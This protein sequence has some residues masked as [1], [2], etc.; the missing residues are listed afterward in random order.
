MKK[1]LDSILFY[2]LTLLESLFSLRS[3]GVAKGA[4]YYI[5]KSYQQSQLQKSPFVQMVK[6]NP[7]KFP[8]SL[9]FV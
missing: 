7:G 5:Q 2:L 8:T 6:Y 1:L 3:S 4:I 9:D